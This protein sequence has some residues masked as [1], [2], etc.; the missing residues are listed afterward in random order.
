MC[1]TDFTVFSEYS[2]IP[3]VIGAEKMI[4]GFCVPP[5]FLWDFVT[6]ILLEVFISTISPILFVQFD[7]F[8]YHFTVWVHL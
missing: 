2:Y 5:F 8:I 6:S 1:H 4:F 7:L 3:P